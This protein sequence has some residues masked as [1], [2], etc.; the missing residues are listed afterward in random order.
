MTKKEF[1]NFISGRI[2]ILD[3]STG[4]NLIKAGMPNGVCPEKWILEN[5]EVIV[6]LQSRYIEAGSEII[7]APTF[8]ANRIKLNEFGL[9]SRIKEINIELAKLARK[10]A[11]GKALVA[12]DLTMTGQ[13]LKPLG[14]LELEE[15]IDVYKEQ[16]SYLVEGGVDL[17][18]VET[19]TSLAE[20]R[21]ALIAASEVCDLPMM[22]SLTFEADG[23]TL[24]GTDPRTAAVVLKS[25]GAAA[26]GVNCGAGPDQMIGIISEMA[27]VVDL[28]LIAKPNAGLPVLDAA[29]Q[30][31]YNLPEKEFAESMLPLI[32]AGVTLIGGCCGTTPDYIKQLTAKY[33]KVTPKKRKMTENRHL[34]SERKTI[35]FGLNDPFIIVGER[36]NPTGKKKLKEELKNGCLDLVLSFAEEQE[37]AGASILDVNMGMEGIDEKEMMRKAINELSVTTSLPLAI[38][39]SSPQVIETALRNYPGRALI[40]SISLEKTKFDEILPLAKKYGAMFILLPL[41]DAGL[42]ADISEKI[43]IIKKITSRAIELGIPK[44]DIIVDALVTTIG[45]NKH[46]ALEAIETIKYCREKGYPTICGLSN[47][48]F[49]LPERG[50]INTAFLTMAVNAGLTMAIMNPEQ[51]MAVNNVMAVDMLL[52][53]EGADLRYIDHVSQCVQ[54]NGTPSTLKKRSNGDDHIHKSTEVK[55]A[56]LKGQRTKILELV[57]TTLD[58]GLT[59]KEILDGYLLPAI[60]EVGILFDQGTYFLPQLIASAETMK[61]AIEYLE[62]ILKQTDSGTPSAKIIIATVAGDIHDIG[63]NLVVL[64]L[65]NHG[66]EVID[67]GKDVAGAEIINQAKAHQ[68]DIIA[69]SALMTT[70][71]TE[72]KNVVTLAKENNLTTKVIIGGAVITAEYA[73]EIGAAGYAKDAAE[74]VRLVQGL[75][76]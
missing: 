37:N 56:V 71:M 47:I 3:G 27:E 23:R 35:S 12:G 55:T 51:T 2:V 4:I 22:A 61:T 58:S 32:E 26:I 28:P 29:G 30:T 65:K 44:E 31:V 13:L 14:D 7:Y 40:N 52:N 36:I 68:A 10:T 17:L 16:I 38:D 76:K 8:T 48:S 64:M 20:T 66:Y 6:S 50:Y 60:N 25:L 34:S 18:V 21:A 59:P 53:R 5:P 42:P 46:A 57:K 49:G 43:D 33:G 39:S 9:E 1:N 45:A 54:I 70:T 74:A 73:V 24:Y 67:L 62:P 41:S 72:M 69:L 11:I 15:L 63:K 75:L 19:M